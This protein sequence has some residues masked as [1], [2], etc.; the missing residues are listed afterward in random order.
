MDK[1]KIAFIT[2]ISDEYYYSMGAHKLI[3]S[4]KYFHPDIPFHV[5]NSSDV[6]NLH[7]A[8]GAVM[9]FVMSTIIDQ[10][11]MV[12][13]FDADSMIVG[14]LDELLAAD[15]PII[16]VRNNNDLGKAGKDNPLTQPGCGIDSYLNA[17]LVGTTSKQFVN[18][19]M[20]ANSHYGLMLPF[21]EQTVLNSLTRKY[22][23]VILDGPDSGVYYGVSGLYGNGEENE[24]HWDSWREIEVV[25]EDLMLKGKK[26]KVLH[27]AGGHNPDKLGFYM[28][29]DKTRERL[30]EIVYGKK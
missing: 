2:N 30:E 26:V 21:V 28:F 12:V 18:E 14:P 10:Y 1:R 20:D 15:A 3:Q 23:T 5:L 4:A 25:G 27:H 13:R 8:L 24:T 11:D 7:V 6:D 22:K 9:P 17:G 29:N 19:W 16:G